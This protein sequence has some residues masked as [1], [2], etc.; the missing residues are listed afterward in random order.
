[1]PI[2]LLIAVLVLTSPPAPGQI[3]LQSRTLEPSANAT[4][5][6]LKAL[7]AAP[8][9]ALHGMATFSRIPNDKERA[10][11]E[12]L[13]IAVLDPFQGLSYL[14]RVEKRLDMRA[15][16]PM[17]LRVQLT[18]LAPQD[19]VAPALWRG[20]YATY[21]IRARD[22][23]PRNYVL[24]P[25]GTL[26]LM[27]RMHRGVPD[28]ESRAV[29]QK[30]TQSFE[31]RTNETW[32]AVV[33]PASLHLLAE[34]D[35]V[36]W[37]GPGQLP[38]LPENDR[39]RAEI[40]ADSVQNFNVA[41]GQVHGV[42]GKGVTVG[43]FDYGMDIHG[44]VVGRVIKKITRVA[45]HATHE[46]G[47][48]AGSG[49]KSSGH[50]SENAGNGGTPY[51]WRG[52]APLAELIDA[53]RDNSFDPK[54]FKDYI[55]DL[56]MDVSNHSY[57]ISSDGEY[58]LEDA[59][60]DQF[61][62]GDAFSG[63][64]QIPGRLQV[65]S[66]GN[67]GQAP[68]DVGNQL[69]YF[70]LTKQ[71]KN[72]LVVGGWDLVENRIDRYSSLGPAH[73]GRIKPDVVAPSRTVVSFIDDG[74]DGGVKSSGFCSME[75][76]LP[77]CLGTPGFLR[78][79]FYHLYRGTSMASAATTG[80]VALVL[81]QYATT[82]GVN[83]DLQ[84]PLP[85]TLRGVM[86]HTARDKEAA[87]P[88]TP[89]NEDG[90][91]QA[92]RG[93]DFATGWGTIDAQAAVNVVADRRLVEGKLTAGCQVRTYLFTVPPGATGSTRIT[94]AWDDVASNA[95]AAATAPKLVNDLDLVLV[96]PNGTRHYPW[97]L[98][99]K[100]VDP[101]GNTIPDAL[102]VCGTAITVKRQFMPVANPVYVSPGNPSNVNDTIPAGGVPAATASGRDHL[103]NVEVVDAPA[104]AGTWRAEV[105]GFEVQQGPQNFSL[106]GSSLT[107]F[108]VHPTEVCTFYPKL[109][110]T[111]R[112]RMGICERFPKICATKISFPMRGLV[113]IGFADLTQKIILPLDRSCRYAIN[114]PV[115]GAGAPCRKLDLQLRTTGT[116]LQAAVYSSQ[117]RLVKR[118]TSS[119][120][121]KSLRFTIR[122][123]EQ[124]FV[125]LS[126][127][128]GTRVD[129]DYDV[130]L[131]L[132]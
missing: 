68:L 126:P 77:Q 20:D 72:M 19:R 36:Q 113:R 74:P 103:N 14:A 73:D 115:C 54:T 66:A 124:Y 30:N 65:T 95:G 80:A 67:S 46:A 5:E 102:Q 117:G 2:A 99:Q 1:M 132:R 88:W 37:I 82:Y 100:I 21:V 15:L 64:T 90:A 89:G 104:V 53:D 94:L 10:Q 40:N 11:L 108:T 71:A 3:R 87:A 83:L 75:S 93:P 127:G 26:K 112:V 6:F 7:K 105:T 98:D 57:P 69:G 101:T 123:G 49:V 96:D 97:Q 86:I 60:H 116:S 111:L 9:K 84:P 70:S 63:T 81:E 31:R 29:L 22:E 91:V 119:S 38:F 128:Q 51:Q 92:Y 50:D 58:S 44:D 110:A 45:K 131:Q 85:S 35:A 121:G 25:E 52:V 32:T 48:V 61:I 4:T 129:T 55:V 39:T 18:A 79:N 62:R 76:P 43:I 130:S 13:G 47:T 107:L 56:G 33:S 125:V 118:N 59:N 17:E 78:R 41:T 8:G 34:A 106:I 28:A 27:V 120:P 109:C 24:T 12:R 114:C 122:H 16:G 23:K 42:G